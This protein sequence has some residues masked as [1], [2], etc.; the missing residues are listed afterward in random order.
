MIE[1][2]IAIAEM[3]G[4]VEEQWYPPNK[5]YG[6]TGR[7]WKFPKEVAQRLPSTFL[8]VAGDYGLKFHS[9]ANWQFEAI[10]WIERQKMFEDNLYY[11]QITKKHCGI[12]TEE[13]TINKYRTKEGFKSWEYFCNINCREN[14]KKEAIFEALYQFSQYLKQK[15]EV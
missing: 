8:Q 13:H 1:K 14:T 4:A 2:N 10:D 12:H 15:N 3:I 7:Y 9:D 5:D 11:V 6:S